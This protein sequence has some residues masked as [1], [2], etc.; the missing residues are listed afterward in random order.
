M[1]VLG[2]KLQSSG[3]ASSAL[4]CWTISLASSC[5]CNYSFKFCVVYVC[6][7][8]C[9]YT[10]TCE[11][12]MEARREHWVSSST[13]ST[14]PFEAGSLLELGAWIFVTGLEASKPQQLFCLCSS[15]RYAWGARFVNEHWDPNSGLHDC[16]ASALNCCRILP[17]PYHSSFIYKIIVTMLRILAENN[18]CFC[19]WYTLMVF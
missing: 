2:T 12:C 8:L 1:L 19:F 13:R 7:C 4:N 10:H 15:Q 9:E 16:K 5:H 6:V 17:S 14:I 18:L 11:A 3:T